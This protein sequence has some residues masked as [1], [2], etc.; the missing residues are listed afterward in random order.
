MAI[1]FM[2]NGTECSVPEGS[3]LK[4]LIK[5]LE[6]TDQSLSILVNSRMVSRRSW[7]QAL[8]QKDSVEISL[9]TPAHCGTRQ[10]D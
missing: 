3:S 7:M 10:R 4:Y 9:A 5:E 1:D 2:L 6:L 8:Q